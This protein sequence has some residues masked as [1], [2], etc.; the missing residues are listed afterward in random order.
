LASPSQAFP[1]LAGT[2]RVSSQL[3]H[4]SALIRTKEAFAFSLAK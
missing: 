2:R 1:F 3:E 4:W